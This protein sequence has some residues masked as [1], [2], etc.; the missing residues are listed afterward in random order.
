VYVVPGA[1][2]VPV[3]LIVWGANAPTSTR[4]A[5][6][7]FRQTAPAVLLGL[8]LV[9]VTGTA[10]ADAARAVRTVDAAG[11]VFGDPAGVIGG[12]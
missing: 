1:S 6:P 5:S 4:S 9:P 10:S 8:L 12:R 11:A 7:P 3:K 2:P